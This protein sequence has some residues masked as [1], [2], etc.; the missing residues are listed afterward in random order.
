[1]KK[2]GV[3]FIVSVLIF[4]A[5]VS[6]A[7]D[8]F[9]FKNLYQKIEANQGMSLVDIDRE[10]RYAFIRLDQTG[11]HYIS[12][13]EYL[14]QWQFR[15]GPEGESMRVITLGGFKTM[16]YD[17]DGKV[18]EDEFVSTYFMIFQNLD[19]NKDMFVSVEEVKRTPLK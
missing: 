4:G 15:P 7:Y 10:I 8:D 6:L 18:S 3:Y 17:Q 2:I 11:D 19:T 12:S 13:G 5:S 1:M 14:D 16:D 9:N